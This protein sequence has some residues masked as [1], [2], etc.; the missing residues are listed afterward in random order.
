MDTLLKFSS[1]VNL[2]PHIPPPG[3]CMLGSGW[4]GR[5]HFF[6][7]I[8]PHVQ[9]G[10]FFVTAIS[11]ERK[12]GGVM[13]FTRKAIAANLIQEHLDRFLVPHEMEWEVR[14]CAESW[15]YHKL[16]FGSPEESWHKSA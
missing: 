12:R 3:S 2:A 14:G 6:V 15:T 11:A 5:I 1:P 8:W 4:R 10:F 13:D 9:Q 7:A 16:A